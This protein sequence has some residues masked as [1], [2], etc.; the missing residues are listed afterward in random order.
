MPS[1][2]FKINGVDLGSP[3]TQAPYSIQ[4]T[5]SSPGTFSVTYEVTQDNG[6]KKLSKA[7]SVAVKNP[8]VLSDDQNLLGI[9]IP[10]LG[11]YFAPFYRDA[12]RQCRPYEAIGGGSV[13]KDA[14]GYPTVANFQVY[15]WAGGYRRNG[16]Y[17][18]TISHPNSYTGGGTLG[19]IGGSLSN[20][21]YNNTTKKTTATWIHTD[22]NESVGA[23]TFQG[24]TGGI[25]HL[26]VMRPSATGSST[27]YDDSKMFMDS[28]VDVIGKFDGARLLDTLGINSSGIRTWAERTLPTDYSQARDQAEPGSG[29]GFAGRG[30]SWEHVAILGNEVK[31]KYPH[32]KA[33]WIC[34]P[35]RADDN[36]VTQMF[37]LLRDSLVDGVQLLVEFGNEN[38]NF[39]QPFIHSAYNRD[40]AV[41][42][43]AQPGS[44]LDYDGE[45]G[46]YTLA[47][48]RQAKRSVDFYDIASAVYGSAVD[49]K[50]QIQLQWQQR[51]AQATA[52]IMCK[53]AD[54]G[55]NRLD[56]IGKMGL[57][58]S[59]YYNPIHTD[60]G[61]TIDNIWDSGT[62]NPLTWAA[63]WIQFDV[64][65]AVAY[66]APTGRPSFNN[67]E[68]CTS[69]DKVEAGN[70]VTQATA[71]QNNAIMKLANYDARMTPDV[72]EHVDI[73][74]QHGAKWR[75][76]YKLG[77]AHDNQYEWAFLYD[78]DD[79]NTPKMNAIQTLRSRNKAAVTFGRTAPFTIDGSQFS[80]NDRGF[81]DPGTGDYQMFPDETVSYTFRVTTAGN[82]SFSI[83]S[84]SNNNFKLLLGTAVLANSIATVAN[85]F[86]TPVVFNCPAPGLYSF[87]VQNLSGS[88][89]FLKSVRVLAV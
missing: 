10:A 27:P 46:E 17:A 33:L 18:I 40:E 70:G 14:N 69:F 29:F 23:L 8:T 31:A 53:F 82:Y 19:S 26:K 77:G 60:P 15:I 73:S 20:I 36:Y 80:I 11:D 4:W 44:P 35:V 56:A 74:S 37:T 9:N 59:W 1:V 79:Y 41:I 88:N 38:W 13:A 57:G 3:V 81:G 65:W 61:L 78:H 72:I 75:F 16:T 22:P 12:A 83:Q 67:Y 7:R 54:K 30:M 87:R 39:G 6:T 43:A 68:G 21:S 64:H 34:V 76:C 45:T 85:T 25:T 47:W 50:V 55:L 5:P 32:F 89:Q 71:D 63:E 86:T 84:P 58:G 24:F 62:M 28:M 49:T 52:A 66:S 48:R 42:E 51:N 2:Q